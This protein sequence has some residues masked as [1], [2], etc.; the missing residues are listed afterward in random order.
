[1]PRRF[2]LPARVRDADIKSGVVVM[3]MLTLL[4]SAVA[5]GSNLAFSRV[6]SPES[7]GDLTALLALAVVISVPTGAAQTVVAA[8]VAAHNAAGEVD[9]IVYIV[10]YALAHVCLI[11]TVVMLL[12]IAAIPFVNSALE[13]Q[14]LGAAIALTP[15]IWL[16]FPVPIVL[17]VLQGL[18]RYVAFG[19][20]SLAIALSRPAFGIPWAKSG[21]GAGGA[22]A[23]QAIGNII[24][25]IAAGFLLRGWWR[26]TGSGAGKAGLKRKPNVATVS[27]SGAFVAFAVISNFDI[28]LAKLFLTP[29]E[30]GVYAALATV[31]KILIFLP[32]AIAVA[33]VPSAARAREDL[34]ERGKALRVAAIAVVSTTAVVAIP[35]GLMPEKTIELMFGERYIGGAPGV[36]PMMFAGTGLALLYLLVVYSVTIEDRRW[37]LLLVMGVGLQVLGIWQFHD[38]PAQIASVQAFVVGVVLIVNEARFHSLFRPPR[39]EEVPGAP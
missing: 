19:F 33:L 16:V 39:A 9:R 13:L 14:A 31:G 2:P 35:I 30:V 37:M 15:V 6:L 25:L 32:G 7:F 27:A 11:A 18:E 3:V 21:G 12:Y 24:V 34:R 1:M 5:Y 8:R 10:R 26:R 4:S 17:G 20:M 38:S 23:G 36:L 29:R 22:L 28:V